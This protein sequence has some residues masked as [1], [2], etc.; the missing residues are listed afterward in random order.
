M[1]DDVRTIWELI[2]RRAAAT[3]DRVM[4]YDGDRVTTFAE[5]RELSERAAAGL[6]GL[7]VGADVNVSWQLPT[8]TES[9]V[10]VGALCRLGAVQN[11][12]LPIY[13]AREISFIAKQTHCKLLVT[14]SVWNNFDY[15]ALA[16]QIAGENDGMHTLV[17]DHWN[18]EGDPATLPPAAGAARRSRGRSDPLDLLHVGHDRGAE[19]RAAHRSL[20]ARRRD[21]LRAQ[22]A[23]GGRRHRARR[24]PVHARGRHHHRRVHAAAHRL[25]RGA[26]GGVDA[27]GLDRADPQARRDARQRRGR[28][29]RGAD[30]RGEGRS[31]RVQDGA[32]LPERRI[33]PPAPAARRA[34]GGGAVEHRHDRGLRHDRG[35][36]RL[37]DRHRRP[38]RREALRRGH[39]Q[40]RRHDQAHRP[41]RQG[42]ADGRGGRGRGEGPAGD[43][44]LRRQ[45]ARRRRVHRPTASC[46]PATSRRFDAHGAI[47]ITGR[48]KDIIIRKGENV[49][50]KEVEDVLYTHPAIA[51]VAVLGIPDR[52][53]ARWWSRSSCPPTRHPRRP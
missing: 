43:A 29:P 41:R 3:P 20:G 27:A 32:R 18:P 25:G 5:Y 53:A 49:S 46:T 16:E 11:P 30:R 38:R 2:E 42:G 9:A 10:L 15:G 51:D 23:R 1:L 7:G 52:I 45:L 22:D 40:R 19:G 47:L 24:V 4:L 37:P 48:I 34:E 44:G 50:A 12:M 39:A 31:R 35:A 21:R 13:R 17:A 26:H 33:G 6:L 36:D 8:W 28:D 14:P